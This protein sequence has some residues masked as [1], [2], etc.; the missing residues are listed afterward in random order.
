MRTVENCFIANG[1]TSD[2]RK[3]QIVY[4]LIDKKKG[5]SL[6]IVGCYVSR[7]VLFQRFK[8]EFL[9]Y[10]LSLKVTEFKH[11]TEA[12]TNIKLSA[13]NM[14][15]DITNMKALSRATVETYLRNQALTKNKFDES[16][17]LPV[18]E[19]DENEE[20]DEPPIIILDLL[21]NFL[22]HVLMASQLNPKIYE[23]VQNMGPDTP[24]T[25]LISDTVKA[26]EA[27]NQKKGNKTKI[28]SEVIW[29]V[30]NKRPAVA[31]IPNPP[32]AQQFSKNNIKSPEYNKPVPKPNYAKNKM[33]YTCGS[34][35]H[36]KKECNRCQACGNIKKDP[37][38]P[39]E[40]EIKYCICL[41][42][43]HRVDTCKLS[44]RAA[45]GKYFHYCRA[46]GSRTY[47]ECRR[48]SN[49]Q[50]HVKATT[51]DNDVHHTQQDDYIYEFWENVPKYDWDKMKI[52]D[53]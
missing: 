36:L 52:D 14:T 48:R 53:Q 19:D 11:A 27:Y 1:I 44:R 43:N 18:F 38:H 49:A 32:Q 12:L 51:D 46:A 33:C 23:K 45:P 30:D 41:R 21:Q 16:S 7:K 47:S 26:Q 13:E 40:Y 6:S 31:K 15:C 42:T 10:F 37:A 17:E 34:E 24:S 29:K 50:H 2:E 4:S 28:K 20:N 39:R 9:G 3:I 35:S 22:L 25:G 8:K 5:T